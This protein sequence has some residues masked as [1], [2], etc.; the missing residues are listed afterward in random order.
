[1]D[2]TTCA[3]TGVI[4]TPPTLPPGVTRHTHAWEEMRELAAPIREFAC[5]KCWRGQMKQLTEKVDPWV[6]E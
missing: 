1:M 4:K 3:D 6:G 2:C 5:P